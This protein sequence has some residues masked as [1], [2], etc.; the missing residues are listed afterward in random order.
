MKSSELGP[1]FGIVSSLCHC[2]GLACPC[3]VASTNT[4]LPHPRVF[5][6]PMFILITQKMWL[7][8]LLE[9]RLLLHL[10]LSMTS[11]TATTAPS[12]TTFCTA[13]T[14]SSNSYYTAPITVSTSYYA[15]LLLLV[16]AAQLL[17]ALVLVLLLPYWGSALHH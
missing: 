1:A 17:L 9:L 16:V 4:Y 3:V 10:I 15:C 7:N 5:D 8:T 2:D 12:T 13:T 6:F 14:T 11:S